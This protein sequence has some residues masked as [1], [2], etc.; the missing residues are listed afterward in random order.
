MRR[1]IA[2]GLLLALAGCAAPS[3]TASGQPLRY[4]LYFQEW[5]AR[6]DEEG[7]LVVKTAAAYAASHPF[8]EVT[9]NGFAAPDGSSQANVDISRTRAQIVSDELVNDGVSPDRIKRGALGATP[10]AFSALESR[11]VEISVLAR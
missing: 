5:S 4:P 10:F 8:A 9:V 2:I 1:L 6:L 3:A 11:R 7:K